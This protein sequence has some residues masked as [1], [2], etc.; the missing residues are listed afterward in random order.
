LKVTSRFGSLLLPAD[1]ES[2]SE[3]MLVETQ[4]DALTA[5]VLVVP[6]Q[7]LCHPNQVLRFI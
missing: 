7:G 4:P 1:I 2:P 3:Q 5:D 6:H